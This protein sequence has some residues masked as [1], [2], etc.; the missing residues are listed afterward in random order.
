[1]IMALK[2]APLILLQNEKKEHMGGV[3]WE[4]MGGVGWE[5][6]LTHKYT[7]TNHNG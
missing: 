5:H 1:M 7:S 3:G 4:H 6:M 2:G